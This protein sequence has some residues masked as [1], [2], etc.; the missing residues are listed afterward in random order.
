MKHLQK[1]QPIKYAKNWISKT[2]ISSFMNKFKLAVLR[3]PGWG[4]SQ[5][6]KIII[7]N[8]DIVVLSQKLKN[9]SIVFGG[10]VRFGPNNK[11]CAQ[12]NSPHF[13]RL[14]TISAIF[15]LE[16]GRQVNYF[17]IANTTQQRFFQMKKY[18]CFGFSNIFLFDQISIKFGK[19]GNQFCTARRM[20]TANIAILHWTKKLPPPPR[21]KMVESR[22]VVNAF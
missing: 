20:T 16:S 15:I 3:H 7:I 11:I 18:I 17:R 8:I 5:N 21:S 6:C 9:V 1:K 22:S 12:L 2:K 14:Y 4:R 13:H 19:Q 10:K